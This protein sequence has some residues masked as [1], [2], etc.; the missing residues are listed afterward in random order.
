MKQVVVVI[1]IYREKL[2]PSEKASLA[3]VRKILGKYDIC[4][5]APERMRMFLQEEG[6]M[7]EYWPDDCFESTRT[8]SHLLLMDEFYSRFASYEYML[9]YQLDAFVFFDRLQ[10]FCL[11]GYD[12]IGAPMP[13]WTGWKRT[14]VGNG[15]FSLRNISACLE[16]TRNKQEIYKRTGRGKE[17][18][19]AEDKFFGYCG[20]DEQINFTT[21]DAGTAL[22]FAVEYDVMKAYSRLSKDTLPFGCHA[23]SKAWYWRIWAPFLKDFISNWNEIKEGELSLLQEDTYRAARRKALMRFLMKRFCKKT[24]KVLHDAMMERMIPS[25]AEYM[26]WGGGQIGK[27]LLALFGV[28]PRK[29][30]CIIDMKYCKKDIN[31]I[32]VIRPEDALK[33]RSNC[34]IIVSVTIPK[35]VEEIV[36]YLNRVELRRY[37]D[38]IL[39]SDLLE[40]LI[41]LYWQKSVCKWGRKIYEACSL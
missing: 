40:E 23:W 6:C 29:I 28:Y 33:N 17:F 8:Y 18:E 16:V 25:S 7:V 34:K 37:K 11:L 20:Y 24:D 1:P 26:L 13:H 32:K 4:F 3:Q 35:Y 31:G 19:F 21:P 30:K 2:K 10:E 15:G 5:M 9:L 36:S 41:K 22:R 27:E 39:Y 14:K 12:Y 38:Y